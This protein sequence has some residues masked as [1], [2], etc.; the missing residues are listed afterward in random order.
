MPGLAGDQP[1][2]QVARAE[3]IARI[4]PQQPP[5]KRLAPL[6]VA[7]TPRADHQPVQAAQKRAVIHPPPRE[8]TI[9]QVRQR[10]LGS[11]AR[12]P[13]ASAFYAMSVCLSGAW[14]FGAWHT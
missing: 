14:Q 1:R 8:H 10:L 7:D 11:F 2:E 3:V 12:R 4:Q 13:A 9:E 5:A 6:E